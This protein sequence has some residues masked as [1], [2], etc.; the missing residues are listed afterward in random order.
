MFI[1]ILAIVGFAPVESYSLSQDPVPF[2]TASGEKKLATF[3][4]SSVKIP[5]TTKENGVMS[6]L[7]KPDNAIS[8]PNG[9]WVT[10]LQFRD[11][12]GNKLLIHVI[13]P[14]QNLI[15]VM[16]VSKTLQTVYN[17]NST[18][19]PVCP[20]WGAGVYQ[21]GGNWTISS[22]SSLISDIMGYQVVWKVPLGNTSSTE[23]II[24]S[25]GIYYNPVNLFYPIVQIYDDNFF[26]VTYGVGP[27]VQDGWQIWSSGFQ[28][29][30]GDR[31]Y[32]Q[33]SISGSTAPSYDTTYRIS[34][35]METS[36][37]GLGSPANPSVFVVEIETTSYTTNIAN[38]YYYDINYT[39]QPG[40]V[41]GFSSYQ[42]EYT[43][44]PG[45]DFSLTADQVSNPAVME[46]ISN[47]FVNDTSLVTGFVPFDGLNNQI[48][49]VTQ[50]GTSMQTSQVL[51]PMN[52]STNI[53]QN[54]PGCYT[55]PEF[56][57]AATGILVIS[58]I[59]IILFTL[60]NKKIQRFS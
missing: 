35:A 34:A 47:E 44:L 12:K 19:I 46:L 38:I 9:G 6:G 2:I 58:M 55:T 20:Q 28:D 29:T 17:K 32:I 18:F 40:Q 23:P 43:I 48:S 50:S 7:T 56:G 1:I 41:F 26:Q 49:Y 42:D 31:Y 33:H 25:G 53:L 24:P 45:G 60:T 37:P 16:N 11:I 3:E 15:H 13:N 36:I 51:Y 52:G 59:A 30:A 22:T 8:T 57:P 54:A 10:P 27:G 14:Q 39:P 4:T 5:A 21:E